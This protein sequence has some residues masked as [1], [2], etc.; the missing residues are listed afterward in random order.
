MKS[1]VKVSKTVEGAIN[2]ALEQLEVSKNDVQ[3]EVLE[4]PSKGLFGLIGT[5]DAA[6]RVTVVND[7]VEIVETFLNKIL[8][9]MNMEG[10][11]SVRREGS[12]LYV[13][14]VNVDSSDM[15]IIIGKRGN[16][17]DAIQYLLS[18]SVN[19]DRDDYIKVLVDI[20]GYRK[21]RKE[22]LIRL[23]NRM[24]EKSK[25]G[26]KPIKLEPMNPYER[27]IIHSALQNVNGVTTY[28]EGEDPYRRVVIQAK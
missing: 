28:S 26:H 25:Y 20:K 19:K 14:I 4:E 24:A 13:E 16:T 11:A 9:Q 23:A 3:V 2:E 15:G 12:Q 17:L 27:R 6:V 10:N 21:K 18:L 7:P 22:T 8:L 5:K 1:V